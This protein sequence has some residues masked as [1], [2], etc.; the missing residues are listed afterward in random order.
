M[1]APLAAAMLSISVAQTPAATAPTSAPV[2]K[3]ATWSMAVMP[4]VDRGVGKELAALISDTIL[5]ETHKLDGPR[6]I[7]M[8][9]VQEIL[10]LEAQKQMLGC[11]ESSCMAELAGALGAEKVLTGWVGKVGES[12]LINLTVIDSRTTQV[13]AQATERVTGGRGE[14]FLDLVGP[15]VEKLFPD[16]AVANGQT[17]GVAPTVKAR[18]RLMAP[19]AN[20]LYAWGTGGAAVVTLAVGVGFGFAA[21]SAESDHDDLYKRSLTT[22]VAYSKIQAAADSAKSRALVASILFAAGGALAVTSAVLFAF[23]GGSDAPSGATATTSA[24]LSRT[25]GGVVATFGGIF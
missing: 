24:G 7:G 6:V 21:R 14:E 18:A 13:E 16:L 3:P 17:R 1:I 8:N 9:E 25:P 23:S 20:P 2:A 4:L 19:S 11:N 15:M 22:P 10:G 5:Q 12:W